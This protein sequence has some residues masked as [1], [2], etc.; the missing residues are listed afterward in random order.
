MFKKGDT[1]IEVLMAVGIFS[2]IAIAVVA[3]MSGGTSSAQLALE[4]TLAREEIDTQ[5]EALRYVH[6]SYI[7]DQ[8]SNNENLATVALWNKIVQNAYT[9]SG[10]NSD[11]DFLQYHPTTCSN[12]ADS[13]D[14][15]HKYAFIL[16]THN[17]DSADAYISANSEKGK[18]TFSVAATYPQLRFNGDSPSLVNDNLDNKLQKAEGIYIFAVADNDTTTIISDTGK[19]YPAF[20]D[21]YIRTCW[22]GTDDETPSTI[23]TVIRLY[24][25]A[26][27]VLNKHY[28]GTT[29]KFD[30]NGSNGGGSIEPKRIL[31]GE[32]LTFPESPFT[33]KNNSY[34][35]GKVKFVGWSFDKNGTTGIYSPGSTYKVNV[36]T[37]EVSTV[38]AIWQ[39]T[40]PDAIY[41]LDVNVY[42]DNKG[43]Y[44][45]G[46][47]KDGFLVKVYVNGQ[48]DPY[49]TDPTGGDYY[50]QL[51]LG[52]EVKIIFNKV[53]GYYISNFATICNGMEGCSTYQ[54]DTDYYV[55][56]RIYPEGLSAQLD[57]S[58]HH[59]IQIEP[60]WKI[61]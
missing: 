36:K 45:G 4:T 40:D 55:V 35:N 42:I 48:H 27:A 10:N 19:K 3:V 14:P 41:W 24:N 5:A 44:T 12:V 20:Y 26:A 60:I 6:D 9:P 32:T 31:N 54:T 22:Y 58:N 29:F 38:Y 53:N 1:L 57:S 61:K 2:M 46:Y 8:N 16:D 59:A 56:L 18:K 39:V 51:I 30:G 33:W 43:D 37:D 49:P 47:G 15:M 52:S 11:A 21:F 23:S 13:N 17:L 25:P 28:V 34:Y 7:A 50:K